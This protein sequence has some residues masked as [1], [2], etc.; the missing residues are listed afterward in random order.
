M[1]LI[2]EESIRQSK[3]V[4]DFSRTDQ[5]QVGLTL[6][7]TVENPA[8]VRFVEKVGRE[9]IATFSTHDWLVL[10]TIARDDKVPK[11]LQ[12]RVQRLLDL[13]LI[14]RVAGRRCMLSRKYYEF[15]GQKAAYTRKK[16]LDREQNLGLLLK[17]IT[18]NA[19]TGSKLEDLCQV[20]S[21]LPMSHVQ[22]LLRT[23]KRR[24]EA[25]PIGTTS[26]GRWFPGPAP[27]A[28]IPK[29]SDPKSPPRRKKS[30]PID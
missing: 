28:S 19:A 5:Y 6:F 23:L 9:T 8:F 2:F 18:D 15:V 17:H 24:G 25:Y 12:G 10:A 3:P 7:G 21:A 13:G 26:A 11:V 4:P 22:S 14:E 16:E 29:V 30:E 1:N 20:L 27:G